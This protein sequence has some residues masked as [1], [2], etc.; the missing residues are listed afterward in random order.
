MA[1]WDFIDWNQARVYYCSVQQDIPPPSTSSLSSIPLSVNERLDSNYDFTD[2]TGFMLWRP[3]AITLSRLLL[4]NPSIVYNKRIIELGAGI[5]L[6]SAVVANIIQKHNQNQTVTSTSTLT[7]TSFI[8]ATDAMRPTL[9]LANTNIDYNL[10]SSFALSPST[11]PQ[12]PIPKGKEDDETFPYACR[13]RWCKKKEIQFIQQYYKSFLSRNTDDEGFDLF[14]ASDV[15]WLRPYVDENI[16]EQMKQVLKTVYLLMTKK[17]YS[18]TFCNWKIPTKKRFA[19]HKK[20]YLIK[21]I[22]QNWIATSVSSSPLSDSQTSSTT[23]TTTESSLSSSPVPP[24]FNTIE[25]PLLTDTPS[26]SSSNS[27]STFS[28]PLLSPKLPENTIIHSDSNTTNDLPLP[29]PSLPS[30]SYCPILILSYQL[31]LDD[32]TQDI[33]NAAERT[34]FEVAIISTLPY[35]IHPHHHQSNPNS[36]LNPDSNSDYYFP[37]VHIVCLS[38]CNYCLQRFIKDNHFVR[39]NPLRV[40]VHDQHYRE[41]VPHTNYRRDEQSDTL[42]RTDFSS[43]SS[44]EGE[45]SNST[46]SESNNEINVTNTGTTSHKPKVNTKKKKKKQNLPNCHHTNPLFRNKK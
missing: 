4:S 30:L 7:S 35:R 24:S 29:T 19:I 15:L 37:L 20:H 40:S 14:I 38:P 31:R 36:P 33:M 9:C 2:H 8:L 10:H 3:C 21:L 26:I 5:G 28:S 43:S 11:E 12:I 45:Y 16:Y 25:P 41:R 17:H 6:P 44:S 46:S 39:L 1:T 23:T 34:G 22:E 27:S 18:S 13:L 42:Y 32:M